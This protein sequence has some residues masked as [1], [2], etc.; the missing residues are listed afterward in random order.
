MAWTTPKIDSAAAD[1][2]DYVHLN[3]IEENLKF[4][5]GGN[6]TIAQSTNAATANALVKR[7]AN[8]DAAFRDVAVRDVNATGDVNASGN[9]T[10]GTICSP[11][12]NDVIHTMDLSAGNVTLD[13]DASVSTSASTSMTKLKTYKTKYSGT[14][15][16]SFDLE[17]SNI[18]GTNTIGYG[19]IYKNGIAFGTL[20][21]VSG[22]AYST[23]SE[24]LAFADS[25]TIEI[26]GYITTGYSVAV[27][28]FSIASSSAIPI[29]GFI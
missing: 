13:I 12:P 14:L 11:L 16:I 28:N 15:R 1:G 2:L 21:S 17:G 19:R 6:D 7:D 10:G 8:A 23:F 4:L 27:K 24:D 18:A 9:V 26:W 22:P 20:R 29:Y 3:K 25:D 5:A